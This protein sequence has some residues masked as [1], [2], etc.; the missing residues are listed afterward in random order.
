MLFF[1]K[2]LAG[3]GTEFNAIFGVLPLLRRPFWIA[4]GLCFLPALVGLLPGRWA[5]VAQLFVLAGLGLAGLFSGT[6]ARRVRLRKWVEYPE[7][8][9][10][11]PY[12]PQLITLLAGPPYFLAMV[13]LFHQTAATF[14][15]VLPRIGLLD[16]SLLSLDNFVRTQ[17]FFD[18][19]ECFHLRFGGQVEGPAGAS[20]IFVS[21]FLMDLV[22][23]K[24][25]V[26]LLNAAYFRAQGLG[27]GEDI[28]FTV[29]QEI[30]AADVPRVKGLCQ[31]VGDSLRDAVDTLRRYW[32]D[33]GD[34]AAMAWRC[35]IVMKDYAV[36]YLKTRHSSATGEER[37]RI[38]KLIDR[39]NSA[40]TEEEKA[41]P[42]RSWLL[43][44]LA[45][46]LV[47]GLAGSFV[48]SGEGALVVA[49]L[50][51]AITSWMLAGSRGWI[52]RLVRWHAIL[53]STPDR[54]AR[55][56]LR[57]A[58]CLLPLL[59]ISWS[60][61]F[62]LVAGPVPDIF[63]GAAPGDVNYPST[64]VFVL[65]NVLHTQVFVDTFE[66]YGVRIADVRQEGLLGG[67]LTF[68][69]RLVLN[70][71]IIELLVSF[72]MVWF[73][74]VFRKFAVS[75]NA[76]LALRKE[77]YECGPQA[78][79]LVGYHFREVREFLMEQ[80]NLVSQ[81]HRTFRE[82]KDRQMLVALAASG[83]LKDVQ[84]EPADS[85]QTDAQAK[86]RYNFGTALLHE[87]R[88]EESIAEFQAAQVIFERLV[89]EGHD[90]LRNAVAMTRGNI[91]IALSEQGRL[92]EG[93][94]EFQ[95]ARDIRERLVRDGRDDLR[96]E[97]A[98]TRMNLGGTLS[99]LSRLEEAVAEFQAARE[100]Y[101]GLDLPSGVAT[102]RMN[103]GYALRTQGR[104][105]EAVVEY[106]AAREIY[107]RL[108][109]E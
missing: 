84:A 51:T 21:R 4:W 70:L 33:G 89:R 16:A 29:K 26:Q 57:W 23:I 7:G 10:V 73:N 18:A 72:G 68:L 42:A 41:S 75:P 88:L 45:A 87:G 63:S 103:L 43:I 66:V 77:V 62:Q 12:L 97:L 55:L 98:M 31:Q 2:L 52:D 93:V 79:G 46:S 54:L 101:E 109:R 86:T 39:L 95:A 102:T 83:F 105:E 53:P 1:K 96:N 37:E 50:I 99:K 94:A 14:P 38:G 58:L 80:M 67:L 48:L 8:Q 19:A 24:L 61:L 104:L 25:A 40:A 13:V 28:L 81:T 49:V 34:K 64:L 92:D 74:R 82:E 107:E 108:V 9:E 20:L 35:L 90:D 85:D 44:T 78:A 3:V 17:I 56:Q 11:A 71:G 6:L 69:F 36:P 22:F 91:G 76:E 15:D 100:I 59:V 32:E 30:E 60:R 106:Q 65:E 47:L 5:V 27:R